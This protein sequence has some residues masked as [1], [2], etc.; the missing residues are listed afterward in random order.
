MKQLETINTKEKQKD[1]TKGQKIVAAVYLVTKHLS[2]REPLKTELRDKAVRLVCSFGEEGKVYLEQLET[3]LG[4]AVLAGLI[5]EKNTSIIVYEAKL[6]YKNN[7]VF[8]DEVVAEFFSQ[9]DSLLVKKDNPKASNLL[10]FKGL[11]K[12]IISSKMPILKLDRKDKILSFIND[13][14]SAVIK[15]IT[16]LFPDVSEKTIQREL[17]TLIEA[18]KITKR[19]DKRWSIYMAVNSL[20]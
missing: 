17:N 15:D 12:D 14:K 16:T 7:S 8:E 18:G 2:D 5:S 20:L 6:F 9:K 13:R 10:S 19:G 1:I 11:Q 4:G 3:L